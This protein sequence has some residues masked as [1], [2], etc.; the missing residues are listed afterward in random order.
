MLAPEL[1]WA[2]GDLM[3]ALQIFP[4]AKTYTDWRRLLDQGDV[5]AVIIASTVP[6]MLDWEQWLGPA[7][8]EFIRAPASSIAGI[9]WPGW[10][11]T[12]MSRDVKDGY[13][14]QTRGAV[15]GVPGLYFV[16]LK[17]QDSF[18]STLILG[19]VRDAE[20]VAK[21]IAA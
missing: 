9:V 12:Q 16:G 11:R 1:V 15:H 13:P 10:S 7:G 4:N 5:E 17:F 18:G 21:Q 20:R 3:N 8:T 19:A 2:W 6:A 14:E